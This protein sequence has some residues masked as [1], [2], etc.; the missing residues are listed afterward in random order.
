MRGRFSLS[1]RRIMQYLAVFLL[2]LLLFG[3]LLSESVRSETAMLA[4]VRHARADAVLRATGVIFRNEEALGSD[5]VGPVQYLLTDGMTVE[6][7]TAVATV[8]QDDSGTDKRT[9]AAEI[10]AEKARLTAALAAA[11]GAWQTSYAAAAETAL[12]AL[13]AGRFA[14][15]SAA[16]DR[17]AVAGSAFAASDAA[18]AA[19]YAARIAELD[20]AFE[21]LVK[22]SPNVSTVRT[23]HAG[24]FF[25]GA[26]GY[27]ARFGFDTALTLSAADLAAMLAVHE[28]SEKAV[29]KLALDSAWRL[30]VPCTGA[31][32]ACFE[33][34]N[35]YTVDFA[36]YGAVS[37]RLVRIAPA[38][39]E[40]DEALLVFEADT[41]PA[42]FG[43]A[44]CRDVTVR[45][46]GEQGLAVPGAALYKEE[47]G[48]AVYLRVDGVARRCPV[49]VVR[50]DSAGVF[51]E[52]AGDVPLAAGDKVILSARRPR[53][54]KVVKVYADG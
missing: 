37:M 31:S 18:I 27:E 49:R 48:M 42:G 22:N 21:E 2:V 20:D 23:A 15:A 3:M 12:R 4:A 47:D 7:N 9:R 24:V 14:E 32:A 39:N 1:G 26:D 8:Y 52:P 51:V 43:A 34:T 38:E 46:D 29:G 13:S 44:R 54:G 28:P 35:T 40:E 45:C 17:L 41:R 50:A 33:E 10:T 5:D 30:A 11:D 6:A 19:A 53:E 25:R 36:G 16:R